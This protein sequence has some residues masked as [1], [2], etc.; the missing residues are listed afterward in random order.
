MDR[1]ANETMEDSDASL[2]ADDGGA[3][4]ARADARDAGGGNDDDVRP[5]AAAA[6]AASHRS[7]AT[8]PTPASTAGETH[9]YGAHECAMRESLAAGGDRRRRG[10]RCPRGRSRARRTRAPPPA[11]TEAMTNEARDTRR[12][13]C[14]GS[15]PNPLTRTTPEVRTSTSRMRSTK[16]AANPTA[17][18]EEDEDED[19][20]EAIVAS[21]GNDGGVDPAGLAGLPA[22]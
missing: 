12:C 17:S 18:A 1:T 8:A 6:A 5:S 19:E 3:G 4:R 22:R 21:A 13:G 7:S 10:R 2:S 20:E 14:A 11:S 15:G 16:R 9:L